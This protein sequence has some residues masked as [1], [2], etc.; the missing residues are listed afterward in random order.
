MSFRRISS[1]FVALMCLCELYTFV[2]Q[3]NEWS[4]FYRKCGATS[5]GK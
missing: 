5:D 1:R 3:S 4:I 2:Y